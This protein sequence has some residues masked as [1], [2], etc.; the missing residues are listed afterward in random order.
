MTVSTRYDQFRAALLARGYKVLDLEV[1]RD[2][3]TI[4]TH[5]HDCYVGETLK[6]ADWIHALPE[7][8]DPPLSEEEWEALR[9]RLVE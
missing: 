1:D 4:V 9:D 8:A 2:V 5:T 7:L 6:A 3:T